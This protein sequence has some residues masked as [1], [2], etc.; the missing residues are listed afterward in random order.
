MASVNR[1]TL[2]GRLGKDPELQY[3]PSGKAVCKFSIATSKKYS[4]QEKTTWH[5]IVVWNK[6]GEL[7]NQYLVKGREVYVEGE[8][9]NR[10]W[11][12]KD[13]NKRV[14]PEVIGL[15]VQF[16]GDN[17][18]NATSRP[19]QAPQQETVNPNDIPF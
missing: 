4:D 15:T 12:D 19:Q 9:D 7:C 8:I 16:L 17:D 11:T 1:V 2:I 5:N 18:K 3:T 6:L 10:Q 13:G 14:S